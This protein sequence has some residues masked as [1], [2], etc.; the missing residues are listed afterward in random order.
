[1]K[2]INLEEFLVWLQYKLLKVLQNDDEPVLVRMQ[3]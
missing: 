2:K 1:M 3:K